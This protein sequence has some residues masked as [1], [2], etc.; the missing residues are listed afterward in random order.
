MI[1]VTETEPQPVIARALGAEIRFLPLGTEALE[2]C[3]DAVAPLFDK[4][5][6]PGYFAIAAAVILAGAT[7]WEGFGDEKGR[8]LEMTPDNLL[9]ALRQQPAV[10]RAAD[11][12]FVQPLLA[13]GDEKNAS[14]PSRA[15]ASPG[16][17]K[18][19]APR[20]RKGAKPVRSKSTARK[21]RKAAASGRSSRPAPAS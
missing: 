15:G 11:K 14:S 7:G 19:T 4:G 18:N 3:S 1:V 16:A 8:P 12:A 20:A 17:A 6:S 21:P 2:A 9:R 10:Y 13:L 5:E